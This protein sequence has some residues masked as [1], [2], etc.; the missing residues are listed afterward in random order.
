MYC[1]R[2]VDSFRQHALRDWLK[3]QRHC[4]AWKPPAY[5]PIAAIRR[6]RNRRLC[7]DIPEVIPCVQDDLARGALPYHEPE[8]LGV[9]AVILSRQQRPR[10]LRLPIH[11]LAERFGGSVPIATAGLLS[12]QQTGSSFKCPQ[13]RISESHENLCE[14]IYRLLRHVETKWWQLNRGS[15]ES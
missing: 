5:T 2:Q 4:V 8:P 12:P 10:R 7:A 11:F 9:H 1:I 3:V 14:A 6:A 15:T 13:E